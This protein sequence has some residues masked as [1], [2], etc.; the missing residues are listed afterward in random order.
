VKSRFNLKGDETF[1]LAAS[2]CS[3]RD[4]QNDE[5]EANKQLLRDFFHCVEEL[6]ADDGEVL[7]ARFKSVTEYMLRLGVIFVLVKGS[8]YA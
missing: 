3:G 8:H 4:G 5:M 1:V 2:N 7:L 6:L